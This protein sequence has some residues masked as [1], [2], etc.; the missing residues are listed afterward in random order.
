MNHTESDLAQKAIMAKLEHI[1]ILT[2]EARKLAE[3]IMLEDLPGLCKQCKK[4]C[5]EKH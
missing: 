4:E 5:Q 1:Q 3:E 2:S